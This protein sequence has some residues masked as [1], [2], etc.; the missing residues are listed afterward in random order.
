MYLLNCARS[1]RPHEVDDD[2]G[3]H[4]MSLPPETPSRDFFGARVEIDTVWVGRLTAAEVGDGAEEV[5]E[6]KLVFVCSVTD[7]HRSWIG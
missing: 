7:F 4:A 6:G 2:D 1:D 5:R 3:D